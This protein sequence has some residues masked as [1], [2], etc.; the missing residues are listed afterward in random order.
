MITDKLE[1]RQSQITTAGRGVYARTAFN[2]GDEIEA[3][4]GSLIPIHDEIDFDHNMLFYFTWF[5][6]ENVPV[7]HQIICWGFG[8]IYNHSEQPNAKSYVD[9]V[10]TP[11]SSSPVDAVIRFKAIKPIQIGDE[12]THNYAYS[13][14]APTWYQ[15]LQA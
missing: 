11:S 14:K 1:I 4:P 2:P 10:T 6:F 13:N 3:C 15:E 8:S 12:I 7:N 9:F 5:E